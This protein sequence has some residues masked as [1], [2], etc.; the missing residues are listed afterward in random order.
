MNPDASSTQIEL[1]STICTAFAIAMT[2]LRLYIRWNNYRKDDHCAILSM[3]FLVTQM[4]VILVSKG[5]IDTFTLSYI[6]TATF[7]ATVWSARIAILCTIIRLGRGR[8]Q[9]RLHSVLAAIFILLWAI[10]TCQLFWS[11]EAERHR[12][13]I[14]ISSCSPTRQMAILQLTAGV[15]ADVTLLFSSLQLFCVIQDSSLRHR[16]KFIFSTC[17]ATTLASIVHVSFILKGKDKTMMLI[18]ALVEGC[19]ALSVASLPV[20]TNIIFRLNPMLFHR[21]SHG[22]F[23]GINYESTVETLIFTPCPDTQSV[24]DDCESETPSLLLPKAAFPR[25]ASDLEAIGI[26]ILPRLQTHGLTEPLAVHVHQ[27][28]SPY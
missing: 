12:S 23:R 16:L 28:P 15:F 3:C 8:E 14:N 2:L 27:L 20:V 5:Q 17:M 4:V 21:S 25:T 11:C 19:V 18:A 10:L 7:Y 22:T 26:A 13:P 24:R 1:T 9:F 6:F